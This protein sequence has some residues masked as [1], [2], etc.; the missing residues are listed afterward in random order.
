[1]I[2]D[3]SSFLLGISTG[4]L[5]FLAV[6]IISDDDTGKRIE[7]FGGRTGTIVENACKGYPRAVYMVRMDD[8]SELELIKSMDLVVID[9]A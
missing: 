1:M 9:E 8:T 7:T 2:K 3:L 4:L 6:V 5:L